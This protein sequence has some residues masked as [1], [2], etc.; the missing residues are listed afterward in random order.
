MIKRY[1][2]TEKSEIL[3]KLAA[4]GVNR[5][6]FCREHG[7]CYATLGAWLKRRDTGPAPSFALAMIEPEQTQQSMAAIE[8]VLPSGMKVC[9]PS[10][11]AMESLAE[12]CRRMG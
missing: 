6:A 4:S 10:S 2:E 8:A 11:I 5:A 7:Y 1:T 9:F 3:E 12:F